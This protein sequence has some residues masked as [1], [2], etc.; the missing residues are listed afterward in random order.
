MNK[1]RFV[2][3][4]GKTE[5]A[6]GINACAAFTCLGYVSREISGLASYK[7]IN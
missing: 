6:E 1:Y 3:L 5:E 4:D 2:W 7:R